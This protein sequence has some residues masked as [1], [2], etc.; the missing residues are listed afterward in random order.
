MHGWVSAEPVLR[1]KQ[2]TTKVAMAAA[3]HVREEVHVPVACDSAFQAPTLQPCHG[4]SDVYQQ[5]AWSAILTSSS[6]LLLNVL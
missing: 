4:S 6:H 5:V 3:F 1:L 2:A